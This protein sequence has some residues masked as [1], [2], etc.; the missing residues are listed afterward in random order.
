MLNFYAFKACWTDISGGWGLFF[1]TQNINIREKKQKTNNHQTAEASHGN[2]LWRCLWMII[3]RGWQSISVS[4][5]HS[6]LWLS[7][8][9]IQLQCYFLRYNATLVYLVGRSLNTCHN[10]VTSSWLLYFYMINFILKIFLS[11]VLEQN[12]SR[13]S[14]ELSCYT[15]TLNFCNSLQLPLNK[16]LPTSHIFISH[17][18]YLQP[19]DTD[20]FI[21]L[22]L[23]DSLPYSSSHFIVL[24]ITLSF[25]TLLHHYAL[26]KLSLYQIWS[27]CSTT[28]KGKMLQMNISRCLIFP[29]NLT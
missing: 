4:V 6:T 14:Q 22:L 23:D 15:L 9:Q 24:M 1:Y 21:R 26:T 8:E 10:A 3:L 17:L 27:H 11:K 18:S 29:L 7:D 2:F 16:F 5:S 25:Q 12:L 19:T 13:S 28:T 20:I